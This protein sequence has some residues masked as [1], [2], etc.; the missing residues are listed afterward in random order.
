MAD[1]YLD[2]GGDFA[3]SPTGG[4]AL[5]DGT[6]LTQQRIIRRLLT[7]L[8]AYIWHPTYGAS[9]PIRIGDNLDEQLIRSVITS[10]IMLESSV[11]PY[12][13]PQITLRPIYDGVSVTIVYADAQ[14]GEQLTLSFDSTS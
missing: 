3:L 13:V 12:P 11:A 5:V 8:G 10:Q 14:S 2:W 7:I 6:K 4:L 9:V 1:L